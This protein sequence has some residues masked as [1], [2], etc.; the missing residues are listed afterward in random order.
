MASKE[1]DFPLVKK[2]ATF[3]FVHNTQSCCVLK[4]FNIEQSK[5]LRKAKFRE[6]LF[7]NKLHFA[8]LIQ[9]AP[10]LHQLPEKVSFIKR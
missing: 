5:F 2:A 10:V 6:N 4:I 1:K 7:I 8:N 9:N 3:V